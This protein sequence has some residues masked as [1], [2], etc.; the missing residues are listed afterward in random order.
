MTVTEVDGDETAAE[1]E[2]LLSVG[3]EDERPLSA[4]DD[5]RCEPA[6]R[7]PRGEDVLRVFLLDLGRAAP[8]PGSLLEVVEVQVDLG[9]LQILVLR[10]RRLPEH[11][12]QEEAPEPAEE[13]GEVLHPGKS[14]VRANG[15]ATGPR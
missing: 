11:S 13:N 15:E 12:D 9:G 3:V 2:I 1:I 7:E 4:R 14:W 10:R 5:G 8:R 6:L